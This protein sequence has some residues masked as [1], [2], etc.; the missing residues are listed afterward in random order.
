MAGGRAGE[1]SFLMPE[2]FRFDQFTGHRGAVQRNERTGVPRTALVQRTGN[3][4]LAGPGLAQDADARFAGGHAVHLRHHAPHGLARVYDLVLADALA[5]F[6]IFFLQPFE[7][8]DVID[9]E[10]EFVGGK[11]LLQE[12]RRAEARGTNGHFDIGLPGDHHHREHDAQIA[13]FFQQRDAVLAGHHHVGEHHVERLRLD[14]FQ[15][16]VGVIADRGLVP[17]QAEGP[18]QGGQRAGIVIDY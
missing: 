16:A 18:R 2:Q 3:Q 7:L 9:S 12:I 1:T 11:R 5:Q 4:L 8:E 6:A 13:Q 17:C 14:E 10:Q 15:R